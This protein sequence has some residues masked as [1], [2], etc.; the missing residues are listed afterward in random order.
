M[1]VV[2]KA[3]EAITTKIEADGTV[4]D[5]CVGTMCTEDVNYYINR[6]FYDDDTHGSFAV[7]FAGIEVQR[8]MDQTENKT[9]L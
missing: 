4:H 6:P 7:L 5:I 9:D 8:M 1:P 2:M 3:W